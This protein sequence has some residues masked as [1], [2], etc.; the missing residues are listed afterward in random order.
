MSDQQKKLAIVSALLAGAVLAAAVELW[1][2]P[3][4][5]DP[6]PDA[7]VVDLR[8]KFHGPDAAADAAAFAGLCHGIRQ[9]LQADGTKSAARITTG[10]HLEDLRIAAAE[11]RF[12]PRSFSAD[13]PHV[14]A[15]A[16]QFLDRTVGTSGGPMTPELKAKWSEALMQLQQAAEEAVR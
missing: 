4:P 5:P 3:A 15:A 16:G 12:L 6:G 7:G 1:P 13:Q 8:G 2:R 11:G 10:V 14:A 9:A